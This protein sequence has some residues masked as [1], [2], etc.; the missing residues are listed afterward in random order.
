VFLVLL[1]N[2]VKK[3]KSEI[4]RKKKI[5]KIIN[6]IEKEEKKIGGILTRKK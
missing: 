1:L 5:L 2:L 6:H 3:K 4:Q